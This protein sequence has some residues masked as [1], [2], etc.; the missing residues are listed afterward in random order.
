MISK[1]INLI[2]FNSII[3]A[4]ILSASFYTS[5]V[6]AREFKVNCSSVDD[7]MMKGD[8]LTKKRKLSLALEAYRNA[9]KQD[10]SNK[11][12]WRKFEKV[13]VRISEEG[14]C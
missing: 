2:K 11:D 1:K 14:G 3:I 12:A 4:A 9:I 7:C 13:V 10:I 6:Q 8:K 5:T